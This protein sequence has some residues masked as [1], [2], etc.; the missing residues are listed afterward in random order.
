MKS[1]PDLSDVAVARSSVSVAASSIA[2]IVIFVIAH[3]ALLAGITTPGKFVFDEVHYVPAARQ[4]L[5]PV[6]PDPVLNPMHPPLGKQMIA[7]SIR[8]FGDI[9]RYARLRL[10]SSRPLAGFSIFTLRDLLCAD[11]GGRLFPE[12]HRARV[13]GIR[14]LGG[15]APYLR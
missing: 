6:M 11:P 10:V 2:A 7:A 1:L 15:A 9:R 4:M 3:V 5:E 8:I 13:V 14:S 12:L